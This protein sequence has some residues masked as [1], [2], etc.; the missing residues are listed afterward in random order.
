VPVRDRRGTAERWALLAV[1]RLGEGRT[2]NELE[3]HDDT[4][5]QTLWRLIVRALRHP[6]DWRYI[7]APLLNGD[8]TWTVTDAEVDAVVTVAVLEIRVSPSAHE[9]ATAALAVLAPH[10][11]GRPNNRALCLA[12][13]LALA[14]TARRPS[15]FERH[16]EAPKLAGDGT[17]EVNVPAT[18]ARSLGEFVGLVDAVGWSLDQTFRVVGQLAVRDVWRLVSV[19][20]AITAPTLRVAD[21]DGPAARVRS[22]LGRLRDGLMRVRKRERQINEAVNERLGIAGEAERIRADIAD[23][24]VEQLGGLRTIEARVRLEL[25]VLAWHAEWRLQAMLEDLRHEGGS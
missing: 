5:R 21:R 6:E 15:A 18:W 9:L 12:T 10:T 4:A 16:Y 19:A 25:L 23:E 22:E 14:Q 20:V 3:R 24:L 7:A 1:L 2:V 11:H 13:V 17:D 8:P